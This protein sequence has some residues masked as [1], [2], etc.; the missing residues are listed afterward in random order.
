MEEA[1]VRFVRG[2]ELAKAGNCPDAL[3][4]FEA[5]YKLY[6]RPSTLYNLGECEE[7]LQRFDRAI[8]Y[9]DRYMFLATSSDPDRKTVESKLRTLKEMVGT[10]RVDT[11]PSA[12]VWLGE[13]KLGESPGEFHVPVGRQTIDIRKPGYLPVQR[14]II[15]VPRGRVLLQVTMVTETQPQVVT[16]PK[17]VD[18]SGLPPVLFWSGVGATA[19]SAGLG[20]YFGIRAQN[21]RGEAKDID[22]RLPRDSKISEIDD[23]AQL[24]DVFFI[25]AGVLGAATVVTYFLTDWDGEDHPREQKTAKLSPLVGPGF[26]GFSLQGSWKP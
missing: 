16:Q 17:K 18:K 15:L 5:S 21:L 19:L 8:K 4:E 20:L 9:Y 13:R 25:S 10:L 7:Q 6:A 11:T 23:A 3:V 26:Y 12:E 2:L 22:P 24:A 14:V 1:K